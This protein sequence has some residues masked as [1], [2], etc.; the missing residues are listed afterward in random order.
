MSALKMLGKSNLT[1]LKKMDHH[2]TR[3]WYTESVRYIFL[4]IR[5]L[6]ETFLGAFAKLWKETVS[7]VMSVCPS[8]WNNSASTER[9]FMKYDIRVFFENLSRKFSKVFRKVCRL[10]DNVEEYTRARQATDDNTIGLMRFACCIPRATN[11]HSEYVILIAFQLQQWLHERATVLRL[12]V[13][14][15]PCLVWWTFCKV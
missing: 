14:C 9:I 11:R 13:L 6:C 10:W 3:C 1:E 2:T 4:N 7:F 5:V 8:A 15:L 12:Y